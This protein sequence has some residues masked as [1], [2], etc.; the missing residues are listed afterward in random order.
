MNSHGIN[1]RQY[2]DDR[3][4]FTL[5][6]LEPRVITPEHAQSAL[7]EAVDILIKAQTQLRDWYGP[8]GKKLTSAYCYLRKQLD[9]LIEDVLADPDKNEA[10]A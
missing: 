8:E 4:R 3:K 6:P 7:Q 1:L 5:M 2:E 10:Q 9:P